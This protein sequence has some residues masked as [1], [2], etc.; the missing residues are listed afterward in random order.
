M[1]GSQSADEEEG[2]GNQAD[3]QEA[4]VEQAAV[5]VPRRKPTPEFYYIWHRTPL[6]TLY[7][8]LYSLENKKRSCNFSK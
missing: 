6:V 3:D 7:Y 5:A 4:A 2:D 1:D 8:Y